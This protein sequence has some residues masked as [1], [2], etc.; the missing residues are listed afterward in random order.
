MK[1][2]ERKKKMKHKK[3]E[4]LGIQNTDVKKKKRKYKRKY[5]NKIQKIQKYKKYKKIQK[6]SLYLLPPRLKVACLPSYLAFTWLFPCLY[7][8]YQDK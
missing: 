8:K 6:Y 4:I 3:D 2:K 1:M 5:K 7:K